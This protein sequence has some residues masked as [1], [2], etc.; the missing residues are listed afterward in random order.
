MIEVIPFAEL[1]RFDN[2]WLSARYHFSFADY[3]NPRRMGLGP[4]KIGRA[5]V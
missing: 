5:H 2:D 4:L 1:G 3:Y